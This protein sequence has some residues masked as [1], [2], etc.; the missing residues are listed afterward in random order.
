MLVNFNI[1][2]KGQDLKDLLWEC[3][4]CFNKSSL[5]E[6]MEKNGKVKS[7]REELFA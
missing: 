7:C 3:A 6:K 1:E 2:H 5:D 4:W